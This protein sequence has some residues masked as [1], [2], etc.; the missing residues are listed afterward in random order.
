MF[1]LIKCGEQLRHYRIVRGG[2]P[3]SGKL[4]VVQEASYRTGKLRAVRGLPV[5]RVLVVATNDITGVSDLPTI[6][7]EW[8]GILQ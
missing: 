1:A 7:V 6:T 8:K 2:I 5:Q 3:Q 4:L